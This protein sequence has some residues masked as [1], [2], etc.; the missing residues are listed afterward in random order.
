MRRKPVCS[1]G[2]CAPFGFGYVILI[3][4]IRRETGG[5]S[6]IDIMRNEDLFPQE[7]DRPFVNA[8]RDIHRIICLGAS[9]GGLEAL[10]R[11]FRHLPEDVRGIFVIVRRLSPYHKSI[12]VERLHRYTSL[13]VVVVNEGMQPRPGRI[14]LIQ[15]DK[16]MVV[17]NGE[18]RLRDRVL[19]EQHL[20]INVF[21]QSMGREYGASCMAVIL[22]GTG[23]KDDHFPPAL[24][25]SAGK[26]K[27]DRRFGTGKCENAAFL[28]LSASS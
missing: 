24:L 13:Q 18:F 17:E 25:P 20:P 15:P 22:S 4:S 21:L 6:M 27:G 23:A 11:F 19:R 10:E 16:E 3:F 28:A 8:T 26:E 1:V 2:A 12:M 5:I 14:H 9:A 7:K